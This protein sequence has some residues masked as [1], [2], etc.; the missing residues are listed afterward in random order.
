MYKCVKILSDQLNAFSVSLPIFRGQQPTKH[1]R[2]QDQSFVFRPYPL[3]LLEH[4]SLSHMD[5]QERADLPMT[6]SLSLYYDS[7]FRNF[8]FSV[9]ESPLHL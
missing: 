8:S 5:P 4:R 9:L 2:L 3:L 1:M 7:A 6:I